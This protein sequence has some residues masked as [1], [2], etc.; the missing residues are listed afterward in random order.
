MLARGEHRPVDAGDPVSGPDP[1]ELGARTG[2]HL[3]DGHRPPAVGLEDDAVVRPRN[4]DVGDRQ[5][6]EEQGSAPEE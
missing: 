1:G 5:Q 6:G 3:A 2:D 4:Q